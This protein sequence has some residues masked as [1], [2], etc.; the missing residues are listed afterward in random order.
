M[1]L[2]LITLVAVVVGL[3]VGCSPEPTPNIDATVEARVKQ[4]IASHPTPNIDATVEVRVKQEIASHPTPKPEIA[5]EEVPSSKPTSLI[6]YDGE[7]EGRLI[8][9]AKN[10]LERVWNKE[11]GGKELRISFTHI[12]IRITDSDNFLMMDWKE[13]NKGTIVIPREPNDVSNGD[14]YSLVFSTL[15]LA[16]VGDSSDVDLEF[17]RSINNYAT[18]YEDKEIWNDCDSLDVRSCTVY[19]AYSRH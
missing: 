7:T 10:I 5:I 13:P 2:I 4:E 8:N 3:M 6:I 16:L 17:V 18:D 14:V 19:Y 12:P 11:G 1:K 9:E 15:I